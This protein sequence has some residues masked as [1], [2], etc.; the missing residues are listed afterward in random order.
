MQ[1]YV[2]IQTMLRKRKRFAKNSMKTTYRERLPLVIHAN[3]NMIKSEI[4]SAY[5]INFTK[6]NNNGALLGF[7]LIVYYSRNINRLY[8]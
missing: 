5:C 1:F 3:N 4:M 6:L 8:R 2:L 7:S